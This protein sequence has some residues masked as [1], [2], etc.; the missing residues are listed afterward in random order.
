MRTQ[1]GEPW[2]SLGNALVRRLVEAK[3]ADGA[4]KAGDMC[5]GF[6]LT[7][8]DG[9]LVLLRDLLADGPVVLSFYRGR[10]CPF[11]SA[12]LEALHTA[13]PAIVAAGGKLVAISPEA[14]GVPLKVKQERGFEFEI[15]CDLDNGVALAF[16]LV[17]RVSDEM[18][19]AFMRDGD[20]FPLIYGNKSWFLPIPATYIIAIDGTIAHAFVDPEY[21]RRLDPSDIIAELNRLK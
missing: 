9:R 3:S 14:G 4:L 8:A 16:G 2:E 18:V 5:P 1:I 12:E 7:S 20:D 13:E 17:Y 10:W 19:A 21:R 15:L 11:C 6:A